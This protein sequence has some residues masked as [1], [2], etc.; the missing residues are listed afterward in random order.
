MNPFTQIKAAQTT[1]ITQN[2]SLIS[3]YILWNYCWKKRTQCL[4][5]QKQQQQQQQ[6]T[7]KIHNNTM[8]RYISRKSSNHFTWTFLM[9]RIAHTEY[10][11]K[12]C[13]NWYVY[14]WETR[15]FH[16][17]KNPNAAKKIKSH[18]MALRK[19][20]TLFGCLLVSLNTEEKQQ[21]HI[22]PY[23]QSIRFDAVNLRTVVLFRLKKK[24]FRLCFVFSGYSF[25]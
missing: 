10:K 8:H 21:I 19:C 14:E 11:K 3:A 15:C 5:N 7:R 23:Y 6:I 2:V 13:S 18:R 1:N 25:P 12:I 17:K 24:P 22:L 20:R 4:H 16:R 9:F